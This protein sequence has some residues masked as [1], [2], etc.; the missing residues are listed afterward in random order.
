MVNYLH[1]AT[2][3]F[4]IAACITDVRYGGYWWPLSDVENNEPKVTARVTLKDSSDTGCSVGA[5][6]N[7][8]C[9]ANMICVDLWQATQCM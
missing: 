2:L 3:S 5:C 4:P 1:I 8:Q 7:E 9:P 6:P